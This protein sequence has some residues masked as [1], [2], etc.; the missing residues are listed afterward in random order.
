V[1]VLPGAESYSAA[2]GAVGVLLCHGFTGTPQ[3]L[4]G[5]GEALAE[6]G[7][8]VDLPLLP[9]HGTTWQDMNR[10]TWQQWYACVDEALTRLRANHDTVVVAGLSMGGCLALRLAEQRPADV[11]G[12]VLVNPAVTFEDPRLRLLPVL[13]RITG[14][15]AGIGSDIKKAGSVEVAYTR[16]PLK[17]LASNLLMCADVVTHLPDVTQPLLLLRSLEDHVVPASSSRLILDRVG[18][19]DRAEIVLQDSYHVATLDNDAERIV[20]ESLAF[21]ARVAAG[22]GGEQS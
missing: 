2:G 12:L 20:K 5:W 21:I 18:S 13:R 14:S 10:T 17:A 7:Y 1:S 15:V 22:A 4:R 11:S 9:G 6:A 16:T 19:T 3:S 8:G